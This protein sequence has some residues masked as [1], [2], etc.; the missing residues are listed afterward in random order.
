MLVYH[1]LFEVIRNRFSYTWLQSGR[2]WIEA[3]KGSIVYLSVILHCSGPI[4][5]KVY[6]LDNYQHW[7][8]HRSDH[9]LN[10]CIATVTLKYNNCITIVIELKKG[11]D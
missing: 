10:C 4:I 7:A 2:M 3:P 5:I 6:Q 9:S 1:D 8:I 11:I